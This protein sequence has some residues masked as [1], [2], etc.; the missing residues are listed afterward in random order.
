[1]VSADTAMCSSKT[2]PS[3]PDCRRHETS[4]TVPNERQVYAGFEPEYPQAR[5]EYFLPV[6]RAQDG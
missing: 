6:V 3:R 1:M 4:G 2:C 5:C